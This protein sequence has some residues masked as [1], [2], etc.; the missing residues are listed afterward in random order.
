MQR[1]SKKEL[2][3]LYKEYITISKSNEI[4]KKVQEYED[5]LKNQNGRKTLSNE[6]FNFYDFLSEEIPLKSC[7]S[8]FASYIRRNYPVKQF[9]NIL[10]VGCGPM[11]DSSL[12]LLK[13][14][15][16]VTSI[17]P[18]I[19]SPEK[20]KEMCY[21]LKELQAN[22]PLYLKQIDQ[23]LIRRE[24]FDYQ[25]EDISNYNLLIGYTPCGATEHIIR[26]CLKEN[27][28]FVISLCATA[29]DAND[30]TKFSNYKEWWEYLDNIAPD[31]TI[32]ETIYMGDS[33]NKIIRK[34]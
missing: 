34:K 31:K 17:D 32:L 12:A 15:Y 10:D 19:E 11:A 27:I 21:Q 2:M 30:G 13:Y 6:I 7:W 8:L 24:L 3:E 9:P 18:R 16:H 26:G 33:G 23:L 14:G 5:Y 22:Y 4:S 20:I 29:H 28:P 1:K 25:Q